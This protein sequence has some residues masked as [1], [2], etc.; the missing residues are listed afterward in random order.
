MLPLLLCLDHVSAGYGEK[1]I[2]KDFS[3][4]VN[5]GDHILLLGPNG[6]GKT[7]LFRL[8][9]GIMVDRMLNYSNLFQMVEMSPMPVRIRLRPPF[10]SASRKLSRWGC[11]G[12]EGI[13]NAQ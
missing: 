12:A 5:K 6:S 2:I 4:T 10:P 11:G 8:I 1:V 9:L 3:L 7:T 13:R